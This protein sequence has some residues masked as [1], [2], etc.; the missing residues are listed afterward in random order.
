MRLI[1]SQSIPKL[2]DP[3]GSNFTYR[4]FIECGETQ[5]RTSLPNLPKEPDTYTALYE[6]ATNILDPVIDYFGMIRLTYGFCSSELAKEI[7]GRIA[8]EIDQHASHEKKRGG[9]FICERLGAACDFIVDDED[10]GEV[11]NWVF[12]NTPVDRI[13]IYETNRPIHVSWASEPIRQITKM[14]L[15]PTGKRVPRTLT[16]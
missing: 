9:K 11:V 10:M 6:L 8:P 7:P 13:Y 5:S 1:R 12:E 3:C 2:D 15:S 4:D 16:K 14:E